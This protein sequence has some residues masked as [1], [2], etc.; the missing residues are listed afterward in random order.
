MGY[1][2][3]IKITAFFISQNVKLRLK[4]TAVMMYLPQISQA[5]IAQTRDKNVKDQAQYLKPREKSLK[6]VKLN[7]V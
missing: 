2:N 7:L 1:N 6:I 4:Q 3:K 5:I